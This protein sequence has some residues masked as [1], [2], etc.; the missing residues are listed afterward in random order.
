VGNHIGTSVAMI[1][2]THIGPAMV[3]GTRIGTNNASAV[4]LFPV[5]AQSLVF[6]RNK[7]FPAISPSFSE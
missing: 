7:E 6:I 2:G 4:I 3:Q 5:F 1:Q